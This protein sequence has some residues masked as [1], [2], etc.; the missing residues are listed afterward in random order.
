MDGTGA[1][2]PPM[3]VL[4]AGRSTRMGKPK[5]LLRV[6]GRPLLEHHVRTYVAHGCRTV[7][8]VLGYQADRL[9]RAI[10]LDPARVA[11]NPDPDRGQFSSVQTGLR[12]VWDLAD[13]ERE[14][15]RHADTDIPAAYVTPLDCPPVSREVLEA[16]FLRLRAPDRPAAVVP[17]A[18]GR[19]GHPV[20]LGKVAVRQ[21]LTSPATD[22]LAQTLTRLEDHLA[23]LET[24]DEEILW[25]LNTPEQFAHYLAQH[26]SSPDQE[27]P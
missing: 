22:S 13:H 4:S 3:V 5:A 26:R 23:R 14:P 19:S 18:D 1:P 16:L 17:L 9:I 21:V 6:A 2:L 25:N 12:T 15:P 27:K 24:G 10:R 8:V 7:V 11:I 20:L